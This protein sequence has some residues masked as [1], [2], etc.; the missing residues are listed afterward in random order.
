LDAKN[1]PQGVVIASVFT[2]IAE[3]DDIFFD[4]DHFPDHE[5]APLLGGRIESEI[6]RGIKDVGY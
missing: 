6:D 3:R 4:G 1:A 5:S 2:L